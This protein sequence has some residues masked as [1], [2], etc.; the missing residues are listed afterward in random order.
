[1]HHNVPEPSMRLSFLPRLLATA[2][3]ATLL[4]AC[5]SGPRG[6]HPMPPSSTA[7]TD[8]ASQLQAYDWDLTAA[9][10]D[11]GQA[12]PM[13]PPVGRPAPRLHFAGDRLSVQNLCNTVGAGYT[14]D[15]ERLQVGRPLST[16]RV[17]ADRA[18][19]ALEQQVA[20]Q[21]PQA[22]RYALGASGTPAQLSL[23]FTDG[24][25][26]ELTGVPTP[27]T[28]YGAAGEQ[29]F[30]EVA[31]E[32]VACTPPLMRNAPCLRVREV[33]FA[34]NGIRQGVG[35]WR[36]LQGE[37]EGYQ[38]QRGIRNVLRLQRYPLASKGQPATDGPRHAYVLDLVVESERVR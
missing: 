29:V 7:P 14:L 5:G 11:R 10:D 35:E 31:P 26:W 27:A 4:A 21:L 9:Y 18:L 8:P 20:A 25:R 24:S 12:A 13:A 32:R 2:T 3:L 16:L 36:L 28:R 34:D 37:I 23:H 30:L 1:M 38:H 6:A 17:C 15:G 22:Q 19:M 33:R